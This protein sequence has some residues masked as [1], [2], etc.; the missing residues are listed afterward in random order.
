MDSSGNIFAGGGFNA[1][2]DFGDGPRAPTG[3]TH[4]GYVASYDASGAFRWV[5]TVAASL[6]GSVMTVATDGDGNVYAGGQFRD[7]ADFEGGT[8]A[9]T[10]GS[11]DAFLLSYGND[12]SFRWAR[13]F[14]GSATDSVRSL[15]VSI[16]GD[17]FVAGNVQGTVDFGGTSLS[18]SIGSFV[19]SYNGSDGALN[20]VRMATTGASRAS[21]AADAEGGI[22]FA[23]A[24]RGTADLGGGSVSAPT[25]DVLVGRI[26]AEGSHKWSAR[27]GG[28]GLDDVYDLAIDGDGNMTIVGTFENSTNLGGHWLLGPSTSTVFLASYDADGTYRWSRAAPGE[29]PSSLFAVDVDSTGNVFAIGTTFG[30][31]DLGAGNLGEGNFPYTQAVVASYTPLGWHR[32]SFEA[33]AAGS[34]DEGQTLLVDGTGSLILGGQIGSSIDFGGGAL[35][36]TDGGVFLTKLVP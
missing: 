35:A 12:G 20:W 31:L 30:F 4:D 16:A 13:T 6:N 11:L 2:A 29:D 8:S 27:Y 18:T 15:D 19:A 1:T 26:D 36:D 33:G 24:F 22:R 9:T 5:R 10:G 34:S 3:G 7:M 32:W 14:G 25:S 28:P 21:V 23:A 17:L